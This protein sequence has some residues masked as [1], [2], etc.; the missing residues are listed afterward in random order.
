MTPIENIEG[1]QF[2]LTKVLRVNHTDDG[3]EVVNKIYDYSFTTIERL[4]KD[5]YCDAQGELGIQ[6]I[7][8]GIMKIVDK[9]R[10]VSTD[11]IQVQGLEQGLQQIYKSTKIEMVTIVQ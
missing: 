4:M 10:M 8:D 2:R 9:K 1:G 11:S 6:S 7:K 5:G 3:D